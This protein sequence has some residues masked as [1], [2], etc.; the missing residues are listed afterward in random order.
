MATGREQNVETYEGKEIIDTT[1]SEKYLGDIVSSDGKNTKNIQN[2]QN[3][4]QGACT[5]VLQ[6]LES[7]FF[8]NFYFQAAVILRNSLLIS[9]MLFN[10]EAWYNVTSVEFE[11][12]EKIDETCMRKVLNAPFATPKIMLYLE[13]GVLPIRYIVKSRRMN[14]LHY[15]LNENKQSLVYQF[16]QVQLQQ[17]IKKDWGSQVR[18]DI[19]ELNLG[20]QLED[21]ENI[22]KNTFKKLVKTKIKEHA[23][24]YL[25]N[26]K[27]SKSKDV[28]HDKLQLQ[29][30]LEANNGEMSV[31]EKQFMFKCRS[32]M[33]DLKCNMKNDHLK[34]LK[35]SACGLEE[36]TQMHILQC[37]I[38]NQNDI[39]E[40]HAI[41]FT[42]IFS[43]DLVKM[44]AAGKTFML[45]MKHLYAKYKL[46]REPNQKDLIKRI[47]R[48]KPVPVVFKPKIRRKNNKKK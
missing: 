48:R 27:K 9:T 34:D 5:Q 35:C 40:T 15:I 14:Y 16:L 24:K 8:G 43:D 32:R 11:R 21:I 41:D 18:K 29:E 20:V 13:L 7:I 25:M 38:I 47:P 10:S 2:R 17:P 42:D 33:L 37:K 23:F 12:L 45:K 3:K 36:E 1:D 22:P 46:K 19:E 6:I 26:K 30:Y 4:G 44:K 31:D 28:P 39:K